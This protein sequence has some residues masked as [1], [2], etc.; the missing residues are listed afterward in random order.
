[1]FAGAS[2]PLP[3]EGMEGCH[4]R[5]LNCEGVVSA[6][7]FPAAAAF[8]AVPASIPYHLFACRCS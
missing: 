4:G 7:D 6:P 8:A 3:L 5:V 1:M 2:C